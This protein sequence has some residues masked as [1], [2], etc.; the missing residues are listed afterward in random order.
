ME[1]ATPQAGGTLPRD[2]PSCTS[3]S[4][5]NPH[6]LAAF[7]NPN[8]YLGPDPLA[9]SGIGDAWPKIGGQWSM[10]QEMIQVGQALADCSMPVS[11]Q[12][13]QQQ[14]LAQSTAF[15]SP[16]KSDLQAAMVSWCACLYCLRLLLSGR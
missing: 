4:S 1:P 10:Q 3:I 13:Q 9:G 2:D 6:P 5:S 14:S 7:L 16:S 12:Q 8:P 15:D 11:L